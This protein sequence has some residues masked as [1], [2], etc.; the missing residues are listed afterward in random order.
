MGTVV[1]LW[2][3]NTGEWATGLTA[4]GGYLRLPLS[5]APSVWRGGVHICAHACCACGGQVEG[6]VPRLLGG[7][8]AEWR[9][10]CGLWLFSCDQWRAVVCANQECES[11]YGQDN[12]LE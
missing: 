5:P 6:I 9:G 2:I 1:S 4:T 3:R 11:E 10:A 8:R 12:Q 7:M